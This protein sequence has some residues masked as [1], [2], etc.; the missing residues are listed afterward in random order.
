VYVGS[1][2]SGGIEVDLQLT[3]GR[4]TVPLSV[5][6]LSTPGSATGKEIISSCIMYT[7]SST[8]GSDF[9]ADPLSATFAAGSTNA[10]VT[11][12]VILDSLLEGNESFTLSIRE[13][14]RG[15]FVDNARR[16]ATGIIEDSTGKCVLIRVLIIQY[17]IFTVA[18]SFEQD[19]YSVNENSGPLRAALILDQSFSTPVMVMVQ[20]ND[21]TAIGAYSINCDFL[22]M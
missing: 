18:V 6:V 2:S 7:Y 11:V 1:E 16:M 3:G 9:I 12:P 21:V 14:L 4:P 13:T 5:S 8:A 10:R 22:V 19:T 15:V 20:A 17:H